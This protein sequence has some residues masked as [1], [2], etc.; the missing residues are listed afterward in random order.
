MATKP[1]QLGLM[2]VVGLI[3]LITVQF[4]GPFVGLVT[5]ILSWG[6]GAAYGRRDVY[7]RVGRSPD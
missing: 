1:G 3:Y 2:M 4:V 5:L 7:R 6:L